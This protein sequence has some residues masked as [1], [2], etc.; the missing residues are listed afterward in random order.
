M[1]PLESVYGGWPASGEIDL[2]EIR[3][4]NMQKFFQLFI[5]VLIHQIINIKEA[6]IFYHNRII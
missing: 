1:M 4:D 3:G 5:M 6:H 2:V